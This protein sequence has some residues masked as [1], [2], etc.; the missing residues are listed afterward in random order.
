MSLV[1]TKPYAKLWRSLDL[2]SH[3][4]NCVGESAYDFDFGCFYDQDNGYPE[5]ISPQ[6]TQWDQELDYESTRTPQTSYNQTPL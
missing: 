2:K 6:L 3:T 5:L 4:V 1:E